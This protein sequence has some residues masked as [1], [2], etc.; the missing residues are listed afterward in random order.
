MF[1][2]KTIEPSTAPLSVDDMRLPSQFPIGT[3]LI[4][5]GAEGP[6]GAFRITSRHLVFPNG[7]HMLLPV[8]DIPASGA[9]RKRP[10][11]RRRRRA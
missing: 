6:D 8:H 1:S 11:L 4:V 9:R 3:H 2:P 5:E 10:G 7:T